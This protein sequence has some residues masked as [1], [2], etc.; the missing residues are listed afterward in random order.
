MLSKSLGRDSFDFQSSCSNFF[1]SKVASITPASYKLTIT[2]KKRGVPLRH[3]WKKCRPCG[4]GWLGMLWWVQSYWCRGTV[5]NGSMDS[6][7]DIRWYPLIFL[8]FNVLWEGSTMTSWLSHTL[9]I[10]IKDLILI[11]QLHSFQCFLAHTI[12]LDTEID[13]HSRPYMAMVYYYHL[14]FAIYHFP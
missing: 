10:T 14:P 8:R 1:H 3:P 13:T 2:T 11:R 12:I 9:F 4:L 5:F 6:L 7:V